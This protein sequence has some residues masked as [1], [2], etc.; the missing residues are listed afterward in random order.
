MRHK[1]FGAVRKCFSFSEKER[2]MSRSVP[3]AKGTEKQSA[4][5]RV[6]TVEFVV[7]QGRVIGAGTR[8]MIPAILQESVRDEGFLRGGKLDPFRSERNFARFL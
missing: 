5:E 1:V 7:L 8:R 2:L 4:E 3:T 6:T